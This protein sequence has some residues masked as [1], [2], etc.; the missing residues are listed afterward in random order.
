MLRFYLR[1]SVLVPVL[2]LAVAVTTAMGSAQRMH[3]ALSG[4]G[5]VYCGQWVGECWFGLH[6][7]I[8]RQEAHDVL[9]QRGY[10]TSFAG[11]EYYFAGADYCQ[12]S[13]GYDPSVNGVYGYDLRQCNFVLADLIDWFGEP[14]AVDY[15][16]YRYTDLYLGT[17]V[18]VTVESPAVPLSRVVLV[19]SAFHVFCLADETIDR[20]HGFMLNWRYR[21]LEPSV[22][23]VCRRD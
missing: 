8:G 10:H 12:I 14:I 4:F 17:R 5:E 13:M 9:T 11:Y 15:D 2:I 3:P 1:F 21:L 23:E 19:E 7:N 18:R 20:W 22:D 6:L 16:R